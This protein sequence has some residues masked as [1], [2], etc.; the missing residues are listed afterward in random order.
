MSKNLIVGI[1]C[2]CLCTSVLNAED[3]ARFRGPNGSGKSKST[4]PV[5][6][7]PSANVAWKAALPGAGVSSPI[8]IGD[9]IIVTCYSGYGLERENPGDLQNL[10][11]HVV[12]FNADNGDKLWQKDVPAAQPEDPFTGIGVTAHG[13]ASHTP[14]SDGKRVYVYFGKSGA[15]AFDMDGEQLWHKS[16]GMESDPWT[17][18]SSSSPIVY[19][20]V[21][22]VTASA[23][24]QA[25]VGLDAASG[26]EVWRQ[27][28]SGLDG[29]WGTPALA[30][31]ADGR[32]DVVLSV[33][34]EIWGLDPKT[35]K[36][37]WYSKSTDAEQAHSSPVVGG[38]TVYAVTGR[39][40]GSV[41]VK[42]GGEGDTTATSRIW[43]G[44]ETAR[45]GSPI[46][47]KGKLYL[48]ADRVLSVIDAKT[49][50]REKQ[51]R[52]SGGSS[53]GGRF[54]GLDY[55][56]P[57]I[58]GD[59]L[60]YTNGKGQTFV[61]ELS[62]EPTQLSVNVVS[63]DDETFGGTP[64][65]S[66]NKMFLRSNK[67]LY[68]VADAGADVPPNAS[69]DL[70]AKAAPVE[71]NGVG[72]DGGRGGRGGGAR[73][74]GGRGGRGGPGGGGRFDPASFFKRLDTDSDGK[75]TSKEL[76]G[77]PMANR[78]AEIDKNS[79]KSITLEEFQ[80]S[81]RSMFGGGGRRQGGRGG[82]QGFGGQGR[83]DKRPQR[84][85]RPDLA[86]SSSN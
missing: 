50:K 23:E 42:A 9:R 18:G 27:E 66:N 84:P 41:A 39:G 51:I 7:T 86:D 15:F 63:T 4:V 55:P 47:H 59:N 61:F 33:P 44:N 32:T 75:L 69:D 68:C 57:V 58:A 13:Y 72:A 81:M 77:G 43:S 1:F 12:C 52:L 11:R 10:V 54:G 53:S 16:L 60:Y 80:G 78:F 6:W 48:V 8:V 70:I 71:D 62:D 22:I 2:M 45:F 67:H 46:G 38:N 82:R 40:G 74:G 17:W 30:K 76:E 65:I 14:V 35:G 28:A 29:M 83:E 19:E 49:G 73:G 85:Q 36:L 21:V 34:R 56:S 64:A 31:T 5:S 24:S 25:I 79:D 20:D 3:W 37:R 26:E